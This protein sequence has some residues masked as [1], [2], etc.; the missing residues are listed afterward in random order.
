M[1]YIKDFKM[2]ES[3]D[4]DEFI[5]TDETTLEKFKNQLAESFKAYKNGGSGQTF[6]DIV[7]DIVKDS[8][9]KVGKNKTIAY[10][11]ED[12]LY[13]K[14]SEGINTYNDKEVCKYETSGHD[15]YGY[16]AEISNEE[17]L[18]ELLNDIKK[19]LA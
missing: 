9:E 16:T 7:V 1:K 19:L 13:Y 10:D 5:I 12:N 3:S 2:F 17:V 18:L 6:I 11:L 14:D 4:S 8:L 15:G